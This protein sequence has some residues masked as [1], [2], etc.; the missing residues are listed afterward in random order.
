MAYLNGDLSPAEIKKCGFTG[1]DYHLNVFDKHPEWVEQCKRLGLEV[2]V[3]TVDGEEGLKKFANMKGI[4]LITTND[5]QILQDIL[6]G[7]KK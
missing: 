4:D 5:P 2:N 7:K 3:W 6:N 1:I